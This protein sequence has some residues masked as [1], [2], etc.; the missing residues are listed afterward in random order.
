MPSLA[1]PPD[2]FLPPAHGGLSLAPLGAPVC[3][4]VGELLPSWGGSVE[5]GPHL[6]STYPSGSD[7]KPDFAGKGQQ[8]P[9]PGTGGRVAQILSDEADGSSFQPLSPPRRE[10]KVGV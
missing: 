6:A 5:L 2:H 7:S 8:L 3:F 10:A 9:C 4:G 1:K